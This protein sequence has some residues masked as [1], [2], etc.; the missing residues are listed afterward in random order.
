MQLDVPLI[1]QKKDSV[2]CGLAAVAM[3]LNYYGFK[4]DI[5][6]LRREIK[7]YKLGTYVPQLGLYFIKKGFKV[8]MTTLNPYLFT[9]HDKNMTQKEITQRL[10]N[11][12][13]NKKKPLNKKSIKF[14]L[15][16]IKAGGEIEV[17]IPDANDIKI[18]LNNKRPL[19]AI[20]TP[21][22]FESDKPKFCLHFNV[23]TGV[24]GDYVYANDSLWDHRGG[25]KKYLINDFLYGIYAGT[26][27]SFDNGCIMKIEKI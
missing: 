7:V 16:F 24:K 20:L 21:N 22:I 14:S 9:L 15:E 27:A 11:V 12:L 8:T 23:A 2:D 25:K 10:K 19:I 5:E 6:S 3:I 26:H 1:K 18:E 13:K 17:K 4:A